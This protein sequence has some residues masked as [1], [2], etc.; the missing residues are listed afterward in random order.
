MSAPPSPPHERL[1]FLADTVRQEAAHLA[2]TDGRL[3]ASPFTPDR[4]LSLRGDIDLSERVDAFVS[5]FGRLQDTLADKLLPELLRQLAEPVSSALDNL[6]RAEKLG[7]ITSVDAWMEARRLRNRM[8]HEYVRDPTE[9]AAALNA[10]HQ[11]VPM[12][13]ACATVLCST[14]QQRFGTA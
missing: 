1:H 3:F 13:R 8:V 12:L 2:T 5:R 6:N 4:V 10:G 14:I 11:H 9:L 7:L